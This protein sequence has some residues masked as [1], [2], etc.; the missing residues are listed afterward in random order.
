MAI[1]TVNVSS[2][3]LCIAIIYQFVVFCLLFIFVFDMS[4]Q[5]QQKSKYLRALEMLRAQL[6]S[7]PLSN[8]DDLDEGVGVLPIGNPLGFSE[9]EDELDLAVKEPEINSGSLHVVVAVSDVLEA[10]SSSNWQRPPALCNVLPIGN[11]SI[12]L[13][14]EDGVDCLVKEPEI[15]SGLLQVVRAASDLLKASNASHSQPEPAC[16]FYRPLIRLLASFGWWRNGVG[17]K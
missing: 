1:R 17:Q 11:Q 2:N 10:F 14:S 8:S 16:R 4:L 7:A 15:D 6:Q 5:I 3:S 12:F 13:E 9:S